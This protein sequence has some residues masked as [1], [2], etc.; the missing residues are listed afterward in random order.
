MKAPASCTLTL[1]SVTYVDEMSTPYVTA[2]VGATLIPMTLIEEFEMTNAAV[3]A[4][5]STTGVRCVAGSAKIAIDEALM[6][7]FATV[8]CSGYVSPSSITTQ[9]SPSAGVAGMACTA[10]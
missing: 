10:A 8:T 3:P 2:L 9:V 4:G 5:G 6:E 7:K 1:L